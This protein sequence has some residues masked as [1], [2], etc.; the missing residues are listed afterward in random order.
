LDVFHPAKIIK[1]INN[2]WRKNCV[3]DKTVEAKN[4]Y[5]QFLL[6]AFALAK[7]TIS[8]ILISV[9][10]ASSITLIPLRCQ[11]LKGAQA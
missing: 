9:K 10:H 2:K 3:Y 6:L 4:N 1:L 5:F 11:R 8:M 7:Q